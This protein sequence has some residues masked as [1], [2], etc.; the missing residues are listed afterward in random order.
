MIIIAILFHY[1]QGYIA[2][3]D[4]L[5]HKVK[6]HLSSMLVSGAEI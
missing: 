3:L 4:G 5:V 6:S 2:L 1:I